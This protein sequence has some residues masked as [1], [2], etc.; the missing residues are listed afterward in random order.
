MPSASLVEG[1]PDPDDP[2]STPYVYGPAFAIVAHGA[3]IVAGNDSSG[4]V[5]SSASAHAVRHLIV[6]LIALLAAAGVATA[7]WALTRSWRFG[8]WGAAAL[9]AIP[10]WTGQALF[11]VKDV[12]AAAGYTLVTAGLVRRPLRPRTDADGDALSR[13]PP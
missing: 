13:S 4:E 2:N 9:F 8:V 7:V 11:N 1:R 10:A 12:P 5:S 6:A 3:N